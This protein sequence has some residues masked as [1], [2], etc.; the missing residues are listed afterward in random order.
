MKTYAA[1][2]QNHEVFLSCFQS[3]PTAD[4]LTLDEKPSFCAG[5]GARIV[6]RFYLMAV[7][8]EW[9]AECLKCNECSL[10]LDNE[11]TCFTKDGEI[12]CREDYYRSGNSKL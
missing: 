2:L 9:H 4:Q 10:R 1:R 11:L 3:M 6:D 5:C 12:L 8:Q 7:D